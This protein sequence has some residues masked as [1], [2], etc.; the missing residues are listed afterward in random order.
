MDEIAILMLVKNEQS[1][2]KR[3][4]QQLG[5]AISFSMGRVEARI[6]ASLTGFCFCFYGY[7]FVH[8]VLCVGGAKSTCLYG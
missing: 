3:N 7:D 2:T 8:T 6:S 1:H 4:R 5:L